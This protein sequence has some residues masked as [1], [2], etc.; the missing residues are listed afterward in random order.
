MSTAKFT[1]K[2][3]QFHKNITDKKPTTNPTIDYVQ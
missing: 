2:Y 3:N 1:K